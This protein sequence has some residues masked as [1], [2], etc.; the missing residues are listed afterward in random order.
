M[1]GEG[2]SLPRFCLSSISSRLMIAGLVWPE[3]GVLDSI[4]TFS[5]SVVCRVLPFP[6]HH[7]R[8]SS[9]YL[10]P[11]TTPRIAP[12]EF[13]TKFS[14]SEGSTSL[15]LP[16]L[17]PTYQFRLLI[18]NRL[19]HLLSSACLSN[20]NRIF[21]EYSSSFLSCSSLSIFFSLLL[22]PSSISLTISS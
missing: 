13:P 21:L 12:V 8:N 9:P 10:E 2:L 11:F 3:S 4:G 17:L 18:R 22:C 16:L 14:L 20:A 19:I 1:G 6:A 15:P 7:S 5:S